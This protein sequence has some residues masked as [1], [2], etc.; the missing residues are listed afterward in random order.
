M[1]CEV[2]DSTVD[3][4]LIPTVHARSLVAWLCHRGLLNQRSQRWVP[5]L[6][7]EEEMFYLQRLVATGNIAIDVGANVGIYTGW[8]SRLVGPSGR[9]LAFEPYPP[10]LEKLV[11]NVKRMRAT[12]VV[13]SGA[14]VGNQSG[15]TE[16][17]LPKGRRGRVNDPYV[18]IKDIQTLGGRTLLTTI[19]SAVEEEHLNQ[20][21]LMKVDV[22]GYER[23]V[24]EG[25]RDTI[26]RFRPVILIEIFD[27]WAGR[28]GSSY[29][30]VDALLADR[31]YS[32][33]L[34]DH[35]Q[36]SP[37]AEPPSESRNFFYFPNA[38]R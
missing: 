23:F 20:V 2:R 6:K 33:Y 37:V 8:L 27:G 16:L 26:R 12:N 35:G 34:L 28:Y 5:F 11:T 4:K 25:A 36:L 1:G 21:N 29:R 24:I 19:D 30:E 22:E 15:R 10:V 38:S 9:V 14:A 17:E 13:I 3:T 32:G 31:G 18:H 7:L